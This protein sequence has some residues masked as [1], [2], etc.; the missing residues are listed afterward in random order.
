MIR[1][2]VRMALAGSAEAVKQVAPA[3]LLRIKAN[4]PEA[5]RRKIAM[6]KVM[7]GMKRN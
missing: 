4:S 5:V 7:E 2:K 1:I 3:R 6:M